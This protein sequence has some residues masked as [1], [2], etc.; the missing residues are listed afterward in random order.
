MAYS[1]STK[2]SQDILTCGLCET[3]TKIKVKCMDC[4]LYGCPKCTDKLHAKFK[5]TDLHDIVALKDLHS[6]IEDTDVTSEF[7][8]VK[9]KD[10]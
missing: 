3:D 4:D 1:A 7:K 6:H 2:K 9:C 8:P 10:Q 5:N